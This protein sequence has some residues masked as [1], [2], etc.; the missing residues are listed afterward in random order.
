[1]PADLLTQANQAREAN[2]PDEAIAL[3]RKAVRANPAATE[4]WWYLGLLLY[5]KDRN[6]EASAAFAKVAAHQ[7]KQGAGWAML[8]VSQ[9]RA[10]HYDAALKSLR[11]AQT[12]GV[13]SMNNLDKVA[14]YH[15]A[16][17]LNRSGEYDLSS[18]LLMSFVQQSAVTPLVKQAAGI[19]ALRLA[20][21]PEDIPPD[22]AEAVELAGDATVLAWQKRVAEA[23]EAGA[24]LLSKYPN[25]P[26][27]H[28]LMG[29]LCLV[30]NDPAAVDE[31]RKELASD[32][33]H[34]PARLQIAYELFRTGDAAQ[35]RRYAEQAAKMEPGN[36]VAHS[37]YGRILLDLNQLAD[38]TRELE[39]AVKL[40]PGIPEAH[41]HLASAYNR[42]GRKE[43]A[44]RHRAIFSKLEGARKQ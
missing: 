5:E 11:T 16:A 31:F 28:Y 8:G 13:P 36:F 9:Y 20:M 34:V 37:I 26:N 43:D 17:L 2:R 15:L 44:A 10:R 29:Y 14:R 41:F 23:K 32:P 3:Y 1:M 6:A 25:M 42:A 33:S 19:S 24:K 27:A 35:A 4:A 12:F 7:P 38:A 21:V 30:A 18:G 22:K 39:T 40:A